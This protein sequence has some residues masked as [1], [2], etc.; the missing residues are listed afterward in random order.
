MRYLTN[1]ILAIGVLLGILLV[2][3]FE[4]IT[5]FFGQNI[6]IPSEFVAAVFG[7]AIALVGTLLT[8]L[9]AKEQNEDER[10]DKDIALALTTFVKMQKIVNNFYHFREHIED[11]FNTCDPKSHNNP[12]L[13]VRPLAGHPDP[14]QFSPNEKAAFIR[15]KK[16]DAANIISEMDGVHNSLLYPTYTKTRKF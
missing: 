13:F 11:E 10:K 2:L 4:F 14:V 5:D 12:G 16:V 1:G 8:L 7:A 6:T 15:W 3:L 9:A